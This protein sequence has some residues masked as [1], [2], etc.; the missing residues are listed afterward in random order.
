[1]WPFS[2]SGAPTPV[3]GA[4]NC[5]MTKKESEVKFIPR[6]IGLV[7]SKLSDLRNLQALKDRMDDPQV[8]TMMASQ[9][10]ADKLE[11]VRQQLEKLEFTADSVVIDSPMGGQITLRIVEREEPK[12]LKF[13]A[14]GAPMPI[15]M[16]I[17]LLPV[18]DA[19]C[20]MRI[21]VGAE[22][23][24]LM[25]AMVGKPMQQAADGLAQI[26]AAIPY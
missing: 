16:W 7:Y 4:N 23:N 10:P 1:M 12:L 8:Q 21:T 18:D 14:E 25:K 11:T 3:N 9:I 17:Q 15:N 26:L 5:T 24:F 13:G 22:V 6:P 19:T 2:M 20:K